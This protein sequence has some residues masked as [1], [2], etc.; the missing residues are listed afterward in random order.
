MLSSSS[1][2]RLEL[3][4]AW[5]WVKE[6]PLLEGNELSNAQLAAV[7]LYQFLKKCLAAEE[8]IWY[9]LVLVLLLTH[10]GD[11]DGDGDHPDEEFHNGRSRSDTSI[12]WL[13]RC[14]RSGFRWLELSM[15][16]ALK[17]DW[18]DDFLEKERRDL[19]VTVDQKRSQL[20]QN[21]SSDDVDPKWQ[22]IQLSAELVD[23]Y[24]T[25]KDNLDECNTHRTSARK[26][27]ASTLI[28]TKVAA[29]RSIAAATEDIENSRSRQ[30]N[31]QT[32]TE[33]LDAL[34]KPRLDGILEERTAIDFKISALEEQKRKLK[35]ELERVSQELVE[36]QAAQRDAMD[37]ESQVRS[38]LTASRLKLTQM[39]TKEKVDQ[40]SFELDCDLNDKLV[41]L[42][43]SFQ[44]S[45]EVT[46]QKKSLTL[47]EVYAQFDNA[48]IEAVQE[49]MT[50][51]SECI[52]DI[53]RRIKKLADESESIK[54]SRNAQSVTQLLHSSFNGNETEEFSA[55]AE[56]LD[57]KLS[58]LSE[59]LTLQASQLEIFNSTFNEFYKRFGS[60][61]SSNRLIRGEVDKIRYVYNEADKVMQKYVPKKQ[62]SILRGP[63]L[64]VEEIPESPREDLARGVQLS[65]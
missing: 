22:K 27:R 50:T 25:V 28:A 20:V 60:K 46:Y 23:L 62:S 44:E 43:N 45:S 17:K 41:N 8:P 54:R 42:I 47:G 11:V 52:Q 53:F 65:N 64:L 56:R 12:Y 57:V 34:F 13:Q 14:E 31:V 40:G 6:R 1:K 18:Y 58:E 38:E 63:E 55:T 9:E 48:F 59:R 7:H 30:S 21:D 3:I 39:L 61:L 36:V 16:S 5:T 26:D 37:Y 2:L 51:L 35:L 10:G 32:S 15:I 4:S 19:A 33:E 24:E 29:E 49:H